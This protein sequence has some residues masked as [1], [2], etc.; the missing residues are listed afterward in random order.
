MCA[1]VFKRWCS[2]DSLGKPG[3]GSSPG[4]SPLA[5]FLL[6]Q[7]RLSLQTKPFQGFKF[8]NSQPI[9]KKE[10]LTSVY[11]NYDKA[12]SP[13]SCVSGREGNGVR[14]GEVE[15]EK[16]TLRRGKNL[17]NLF[18]IRSARS[19]FQRRMLAA[20]KGRTRDATRTRFF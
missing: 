14:W 7:C 12:L 2:V 18:P 20:E 11:L 6:S 4:L 3:C 15:N 9:R 13:A 8:E 1:S 19:P 5:S 10:S 17:M 16:H